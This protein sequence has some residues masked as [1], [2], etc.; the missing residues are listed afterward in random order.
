MILLLLN[1]YSNKYSIIYETKYA[2]LLD[3]LYILL[4]KTAKIEIVKR[5]T[6]Y[7]LGA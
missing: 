3:A 5:F 2:T 1:F 4:C 6:L 7:K